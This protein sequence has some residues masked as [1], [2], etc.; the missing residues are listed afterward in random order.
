MLER[1]SVRLALTTAIAAALAGCA[2]TRPNYERP[3]I[4]LP[5][6]WSA[7]AGTSAAGGQWWKI[8][9]DAGLDKLVEEALAGNANL[10]LAVARVDESRAQVG[11]A[12][13]DQAPSVDAGF[14]RS[15]QQNSRSTATA[16][17]G[18]PRE[19]NDYR[20][21]LSVSYELDLWGRLRNATT[22]ARAE[23][24]AT[25]SARETVRITLAADV[26]QAYFALRA[27]DEQIAATRRSLET[28]T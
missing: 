1:I 12:Q 22:A 27:Y 13:A 5:A 6:V 9:G 17:P 28:R 18:V 2:G 3:A 16:F 11:L 24:L 25:E 10:A 7:P 23:L 20:A 14:N 19:Y 26:T 15:R 4:E 21:T 8:Y